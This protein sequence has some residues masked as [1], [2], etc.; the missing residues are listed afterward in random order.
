MRR[1]FIKSH[2]DVRIQISL[3]LHRALRPDERRSAVQ[4]VLKMHALFGDLPQ[5]GQREHLKTP[6]VGKYWPLPAHEFVQPTL[7]GDQLLPGTDVEMIGISKY[8]LCPEL[9]KFDR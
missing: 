9:V 3:D 8:D 2:D 6:A 1:T 7:P 5:P 4:V